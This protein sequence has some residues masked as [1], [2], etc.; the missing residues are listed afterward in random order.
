M[1]LHRHRVA[2]TIELSALERVAAGSERQLREEDVALLVKAAYD[3]ATDG[4]RAEFMAR[5]NKMPTSAWPW[6]AVQAI[7][8][9]VV[10]TAPVGGSLGSVVAAP[11]GPSTPAVLLLIR[12]QAESAD[13]DPGDRLPDRGTPE[14]AVWEPL[15]RA[16]DNWDTS[17]LLKWIG[18]QGWV[19]VAGATAGQTARETGGAAPSGGAA[20]GGLPVP[21]TASTIPWTHPAVLAAGAVVV[22]AAGTL[23]YTLAQDRGRRRLED[24]LNA[25]EAP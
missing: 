2:R 11:K 14:A 23:I 1:L 18:P 12:G 25:Q 20:D 3:D 7:V 5:V 24:L 10:G 13:V 22:V 15:Y 9:R 16:L 17:T 6:S 4:A 8:P 21:Q 19:S